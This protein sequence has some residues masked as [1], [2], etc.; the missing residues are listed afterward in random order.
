MRVA[1]VNL[2]TVTTC[3]R[4]MFTLV[5]TGSNSVSWKYICPEENLMFL[6][7]A[8]FLR[9]ENGLTAKMEFLGMTRRTKEDIEI[10]E[11]S[12]VIQHWR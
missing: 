2:K 6:F 9:R 3:S 1:P 4:F 8:F 12:M 10:H 7:I 5:S 11:Q